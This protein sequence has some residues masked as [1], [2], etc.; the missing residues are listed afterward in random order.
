[1]DALL[2]FVQ[3]ISDRLED[4]PV[5]DGYPDVSKLQEQKDKKQLVI[6]A[7]DDHKAIAKFLKSTSR[8]SKKQL[9][10]YITK[11]NNPE[12]LDAFLDLFDYKGKRLDEAL[13]DLLGSFRLPGEAPL[14]DRLLTIFSA[15]YHKGCERDEIK[16]EDAVYLL[17]FAIIMLNTD[18]H[19]PTVKVCFVVNLSYKYYF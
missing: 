2:G 12:V 4:E 16:T 5:T 18:Q 13:R 19:N 15:K 3:Y 1:L 17:A 6:P 11:R 7:M 8:I 9:G 10:E 14:I